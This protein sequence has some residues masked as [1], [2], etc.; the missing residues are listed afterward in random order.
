MMDGYV[1][2]IDQDFYYVGLEDGTILKTVPHDV[3]GPVEL[4]METL[5]EEFIDFPTNGEEVH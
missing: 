4:A 3:L 5:G 2:D 1:I